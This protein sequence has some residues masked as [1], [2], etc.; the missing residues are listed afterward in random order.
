MI[1]IE[2]LTKI[3]NSKKRSKVTALDNINIILPNNGLV[4]VLGKSGSGKSTLLNLIGGLDNITEG[5]I[6][7][8]GNNIS[9]L[10]EKDFCDYRNTHIGFI[11][12]DYHLIDE[13]SIYD[14][15][16]LSLNL[17]R[18]DDADLVKRALRKVDLEGYEN[19]FPSELSGGERQRVAIARAIVKNPRIILADEP[20][21][22]LD[23]HTATQIISLLKELSNDCLILVVSHNVNDANKYADR[24]IEL[25]KGKIIKDR[26]KNALFSEKLS[27]VDDKIVYPVD[28]LLTE[29]DI[30]FINNNKNLK[31]ELNNDKFKNTVFIDYNDDNVKIE[32]SKLSVKNE[33]KLSL[34]FLRNKIF[35]ISLS[36]FMVSAIMVIFALAL[37][38]VNFDSK[39]IIANELAKADVLSL[40]AIKSLT[41]E[42]S[43]ISENDIVVEVNKND[44][45]TFKNTGYDGDIY[46]ILNY[47]IPFNVNNS[48]AGLNVNYFSKS[49]YVCE[50]LGTMIVD[51]EF[52]I[53]KLGKL[54]FVVVANEYNPSGVYITDYVAD[55]ITS[56][57]V[58]YKGKPYD[59]IC[60]EFKFGSNY[61]YRGYING[62]IKTGYKEK[63]ADV[64]ATMGKEFKG[65]ID[66]SLLESDSFLKLSEEVY[67]ILGY[68]YSFEKNF[69]EYNINQ[70]S[71]EICWHRQLTFNGVPYNKISAPQIW[72]ADKLGYKLSDGEIIINYNV[73]NTLF[74]TKYTE[75]NLNTFVPHMVKIEQFSYDDLTRENV[76]L[77]KEF[78]VVSLGV[79]K[80]YSF[81]AN[82]NDMK[83]FYSNLIF[84]KGYYF[85]GGTNMGVIIKE[86]ES[87]NYYQNSL[88]VESIKTMTKAVDV[89]IPIFRLI[90]IVLCVGIIFILVNFSSKMIKDKMH[91]IGILKALGTQNI[92]I[93]MI[94]GIQILLIALLTMIMSTFGYGVFIDLANDILIASLKELA[95][96]HFLFDLDFLMF[97]VDI[98][99]FNCFLVLILA[100]F[101][102]VIPM[103]KIKRI[104]PVKIIKTK[105]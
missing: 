15:I 85:D 99:L 68:S 41:T 11:F 40:S 92:S 46:E 76:L 62:V 34:K 94:F 104:K 16:V 86:L 21:G 35:S 9:N 30:T 64:F 63:Y 97:R 32:K 83:S 71:Y 24:V 5:N 103:I 28:T 80:P 78:K 67:S 42:Q 25:S 98:S 79:D 6:T 66:K 56:Y 8:D 12:Q 29:E 58:A 57:S 23:T 18:V 14:N 7:V 61:G 26:T 72:N 1:K 69:I 59:A 37:T 36:S 65:T 50:T 70:P 53:N 22:N 3:Y 93:G 4:F 52:F 27:I 45:E 44:I 102:M 10:N 77:S 95:P 20:T 19:R 48:F 2:N 55:A 75:S 47:T 91:D 90:A 60:G 105:E 38:I 81:I 49:P 101:A 43:L 96:Q 89:F 74:G 31:L 88:T 84:T 87:L 100:L 39:T 33:L 51:E 82:S 73:Y 13:L 17:R 54:E